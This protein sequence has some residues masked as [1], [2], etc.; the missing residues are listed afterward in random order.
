MRLI[1]ADKLTPIEIME[2]IEETKA[3]WW[4]DIETAPT[5]D[6]KPIVHGKWKY[7]SDVRVWVS[8]SECG[9][10]YDVRDISPAKFCP[11]C[12]ADMRKGT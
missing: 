8:C 11:N 1:D 4:S 5:I 7:A 2:G 6:A 9:R 3:V 10:R 12:G